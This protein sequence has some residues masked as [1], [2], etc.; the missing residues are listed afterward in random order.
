MYPTCSIVIYSLIHPQIFVYLSSVADPSKNFTLN[1]YQPGISIVQL[2][3]VF[4]MND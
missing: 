4:I 2:F 1:L 3:I